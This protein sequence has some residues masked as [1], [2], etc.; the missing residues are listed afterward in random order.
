MYFLSNF[1]NKDGQK[2]GFYNRRRNG[3]DFKML[4]RQVQIRNQL[5]SANIISKETFSSAFLGHITFSWVI[6]GRR[7]AVNN[8]PTVN[9]QINAKLGHLSSNILFI[10]YSLE[11]NKLK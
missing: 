9:N 4:T 2:Q 1:D 7:Q 5:S 6:Y 11:L 3:K 8:L 10:N